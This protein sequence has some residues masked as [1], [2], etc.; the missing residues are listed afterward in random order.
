MKEFLQR[1]AIN[2]LAVLVAVYLI[3]GIHYE[4]P[5]DLIVASLVLGVLNAI[6]RPLLVALSISL[7][8]FTLG[9]FTLVI[10]ALLLWLT[11]S[12]LA[13]HFTVAGFWPAFWGALIISFVSL[14][15][16]LITGTSRSRV[17]IRRMK[18]K[19]DDKTID[20]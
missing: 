9:L 10:N 13:P 12:I 2:T 11:G 19:P 16:N 17:S 5:L 1:W 3:K 15:L 14:V 6:V 8:I 20:V 18:P 4:S 7:V